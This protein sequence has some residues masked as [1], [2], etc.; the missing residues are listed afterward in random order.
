[1]TKSAILMFMLAGL[2]G[3]TLGPDYARPNINT[4]EQWR[5]DDSVT[6]D[7]T[8]SK[9]WLQFNDPVLDQL[10][11][12]SLRGNLDVRIAAARVDQFLGALNATRSQLYP[13]IGYG[14]DASRAQASRIGQPPLPPGAD[15]Y[16]SLYQASLGSVWQIDLFGRVQRLSEAAQ[17]Q[18]YASEQA[19]RGVVLTLVSNVATSYIGLRALDRQLEIAKATSANFN[20]TARIFDLRFK[21][22][23][24]SKTEV[25]QIT[26]QAQQAK[27]AIPA[28]EQAIAA[29][30]NLISILL[31][32][33]PGPIARGKT[34]DQLITPQVPSGLPSTLLSRRPDILQAEQNLVAA[35]ANVGATKAL[36]F[37]N[38]SLT[39]LFGSVSTAFSELFTDP[40][41]AMFIGASVTGPIFTFGGIKGQVKSA[42]AQKEQA[43]LV[44]RLTILNA[45]RETND[46]LTGSEKKANEFAE[47]QKRVDALREFARLSKLRFENGATSYLD[48]LIADNELF[49]AELASVRLLADRNTQVINVYRAM[50]GG[51]VDISNTLATGDG[52]DVTAR[53]AATEGAAN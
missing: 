11:E 38:I 13:Q 36:Y 33:N 52:A 9:W 2:T 34:I 4:P 12:D 35:N 29:Q 48:V 14:A 8:N 41:S 40:A 39:G 15:P 53:A 42:E 51:W 21:A 50:G 32:Q 47:Q 23:I 3:C 16:F 18:V 28:F 44:Y 49:A 24:V 5:V 37:P 26:S 31:G 7:L 10:V 46:A 1:M 30:E 22:G 45:F 25:M 6:N 17:A 27:A 20:E 19:Q 43:L